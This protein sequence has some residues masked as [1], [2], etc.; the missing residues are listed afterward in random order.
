MSRFRPADLAAQARGDDGFSLTELLVA[1]V[2]GI[3][4]I[5]GILQVLDTSFS[6]SRRTQQRIDSAQRG[7]LAMD[8]ITR[9]LRAQTCLSATE[10]ALVSAADSDI[11]YYINLGAPDAVPEKHEIVL[12]GGDLTL[13]RWVGTRAAA[14]AIPSVTYHVAPTSTKTLLENVQPEA[15]IPML[16][17]YAWT[18]GA[19]PTPSTLLATPLSAAN[20]PLQVKIAV[21]FTVLPDRAFNTSKPT[22]TFEDSVFMRLADPNDTSHG[23]ACK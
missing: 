12:T 16:R 11:V 23:Q 13:K 19:S 20:L 15:G 22:A 5:F 7:R 3:V 1:M 6:L 2:I 21:A 4:I 14:G 9:E 17:Y 8:L 10:P 18:A